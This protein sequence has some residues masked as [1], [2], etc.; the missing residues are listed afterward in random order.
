MDRKSVPKPLLEVF[1]LPLSLDF[2]AS[3][4]LT[5]AK[6]SN[7]VRYLSGICPILPATE[8]RKRTNAS[9]LFERLKNQPTGAAD[10]W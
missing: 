7:A 10:R 9:N 2:H 5:T 1:G 4:P 3:S 6:P 8:G